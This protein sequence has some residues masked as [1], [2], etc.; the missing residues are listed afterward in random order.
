MAGVSTNPCTW[1]RVLNDMAI[2]ETTDTGALQEIRYL[3]DPELTD[4]DLPAAVITTRAVLSAANRRV[5]SEVGMTA[6]E[7][8]A[9]DA[10]DVRREIFE[11]A[12]I[13][14]CAVELIPVVVQEISERVG[15]F[16]SSFQEIDWEKRRT[17]LEST[18]Q[19]LLQ[20]YRPGSNFYSA[21]T[22]DKEC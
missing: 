9:L 6:T 3:L 4:A 5:L 18:V 12:V 1:K 16:Q 21:V 10:T 17:L 8:D 14:I 20:P 11:E 19:S 22:R 2:I 7:Y 15:P 13:R